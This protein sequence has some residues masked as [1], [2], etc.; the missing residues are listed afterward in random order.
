MLREPSSALRTLIYVRPLFPLALSL[1]LVG[2]NSHDAA[3]LS[4]D[5]G[6][7]AKTAV[8][9]VGNG[10]LVARIEGQLAQTKGVDV[11]GLHVE[12]EGGTVTLSGHVR[13]AHE[14]AIVLNR[15]REIRGVDRVVDKLRIGKG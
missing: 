15:V 5:A 1:F 2:C 7:L 11:S 3:D 13:T 6:Q 9:S 4:H 8:R 12:N 10:Q 14:K